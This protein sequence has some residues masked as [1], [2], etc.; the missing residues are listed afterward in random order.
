MSPDKRAYRD[1][2]NRRQSGSQGRRIEK[3]ASETPL[4]WLTDSQSAS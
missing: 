4:E 1:F 2:Q 3:S